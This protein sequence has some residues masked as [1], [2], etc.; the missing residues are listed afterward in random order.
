MRRL[1]ICTH[2]TTRLILG[3]FRRDS[4]AGRRPLVVATGKQ[5]VEKP[6]WRPQGSRGLGGA[7]G[8]VHWLSPNMAGAWLAGA[9]QRTRA[10]AAHRPRTPGCGRATSKLLGAFGLLADACGVGHCQVEVEV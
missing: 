7:A 4:G 9:R 10:S 2:S 1:S 3:G 5:R 8:R 6:A